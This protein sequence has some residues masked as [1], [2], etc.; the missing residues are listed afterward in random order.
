MPV[1][2]PPVD[3]AEVGCRRADEL[4]DS[5]P[6]REEAHF[7]RRADAAARLLGGASRFRCHSIGTAHA[8]DKGG[9]GECWLH[10]QCAGCHRLLDA[11]HERP[12]SALLGTVAYHQV[13][14]ES[15]APRSD[16]LSGRLLWQVKHTRKQEQ[17]RSDESHPARAAAQW[18]E[19]TRSGAAV[20]VLPDAPVR[21]SGSRPIAPRTARLPVPRLS[22]ST[23]GLGP[24]RC[25]RLLMSAQRPRDADT[26]RPRRRR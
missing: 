1:G 8:T 20:L 17:L 25:P 4:A 11:A 23:S 5:S 10:T 9:T 2:S 16:R 3:D 19:R 15:L 24:A 12:A 6:A 22:E 7:Q 26:A 18:Q 21:V 13:G 14:G